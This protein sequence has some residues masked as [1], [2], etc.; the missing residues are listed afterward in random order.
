MNK[1]QKPK[2]EKSRKEDEILEEGRKAFESLKETEE[3][4]KDLIAVKIM[5]KFHYDVAKDN[6]FDFVWQEIEFQRETLIDPI[7]YYIPILAIKTFVTFKPNEK[8]KNRCI[9][10]NY[11]SEDEYHENTALAN[12][13][14]DASLGQVWEG[15]Q[16]V[17]QYDNEF[18]YMMMSVLPIFVPQDPKF[19]IFDSKLITQAASFI[20]FY[21]Q[22]THPE[23][24]DYEYKDRTP[25]KF[26]IN[27]PYLIKSF[28]DE[29]E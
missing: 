29:A 9:S 22:Q 6:I 15:L 18:A 7:Y 17:Y 1:K 4:I 5:E 24:L 11:A 16:N 3:K 25:K 19:Q 20:E 14:I 21:L 2:D 13:D 28:D 10:L 26:R 23:Y 12:I 8:L 27:D